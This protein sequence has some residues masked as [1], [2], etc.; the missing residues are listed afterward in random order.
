MP[1]IRV[2][3]KPAYW[4]DLDDEE[5]DI[6]IDPRDP[7]DP[8][9]DTIVVL[10]DDALDTLC[11]EVNTEPVDTDYARDWG[12]SHAMEGWD[13]LA[14]VEERD[15]DWAIDL[16]GYVVCWFQSEPRGQY[17]SG[18]ILQQIWDVC[19]GFEPSETL[20]KWWSPIVAFLSHSVVE[21]W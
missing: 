21:R 17:R 4:N 6:R 18:P 3:H 12:E 10:S 19:D 9:F 2:T 11:R 16:V 5:N 13:I 7:R 20:S 15:R 14:A 8:I 1:T